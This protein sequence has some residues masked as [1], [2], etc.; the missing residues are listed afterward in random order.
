MAVCSSDDVLSLSAE[1]E[2]ESVI[3]LD[4]NEKKKFKKKDGEGEETLPPDRLL[5]K[6]TRRAARYTADN[7]V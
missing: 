3:D 5:R 7:K 2:E 4:V 6:S 1:E